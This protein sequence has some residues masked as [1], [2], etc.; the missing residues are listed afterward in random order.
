MTRSSPEQN[1][2]RSAASTEIE[3]VVLG[4]P[5]ASPVEFLGRV[6]A[7]AGMAEGLHVTC[8]PVH[9]L[10]P[11]IHPMHG[12]ERCTVIVSKEPIGA[13]VVGVPD[14]AVA[15]DVSSFSE[16]NPHV[17][18]GGLMLYDSSAIDLM[19]E[20]FRDDIR[21]VGLPAAEISGDGEAG[22]SALALLGGVLGFSRLL[23]HDRARDTVKQSLR[24]ADAPLSS[25]VRRSMRILDEAMGYVEEKRYLYHRYAYSI[26]M[27]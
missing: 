15:M 3:R 8:L 6:I 25:T 7:A 27:H 20:S 4:G 18:P 10:A 24:G 22:S 12:D 26:F 13:P 17:K 23:S 19:P 2:P 1:E 9:G 5:P 16:F 21:T 11:R 14:V